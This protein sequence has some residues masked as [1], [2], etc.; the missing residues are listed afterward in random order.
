MTELT[1]VTFTLNWKVDGTV[2]GSE[3]ESEREEREKEGRKRGSEGRKTTVHDAVTFQGR[4]V[5]SMLVTRGHTHGYLFR[6]PVSEGMGCS[7][8]GGCGYTHGTQASCDQRRLE[9][10]QRQE[11]ISILFR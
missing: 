3:K 8:M 11:H 1:S 9:E 4:G 6:G 10:D 2:S 7:E 5:E